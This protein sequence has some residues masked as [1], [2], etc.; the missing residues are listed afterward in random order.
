MC[1]KLEFLDGRINMKTLFLTKYDRKAATVRYRILQYVPYLES[2][3]IAC[4]ISPLFDDRYLVHLFKAGKRRIQDMA[5]AFVRRMTALF[6]LVFI[7]YDIVIIQAELFPYFPA[8][9]ERFLSLIGIK[10]VL[11]YDDAL[12]HQY[13]Q[14]RIGLVRW[15]LG[16]KIA[17]IMRG[18]EIV[19][20]GN[21][22][23][24]NYA[25]QAGARRIEIIPTVIDLDRYPISF[26][27]RP[28]NQVFTIGWIGSPSTSIYLKMIAPALAEA[29]ANGKGR[30]VLIGSGEVSLPGVPLEVL[31]WE[32]A[33]EVDLI[34]GFDVG[35]MPLP[36]NPWARGKCG[37]KLIQYMACGLPVIAS[38]VGVNS[39]I[40][41]DRVNGFL[42]ANHKG[43]V[44]ALNFLRENSEIRRAMG[45]EGRVAV[46]QKYCL[47]VTAPRLAQFLHEAV[48]QGKS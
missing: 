3:G 31:P 46:E 9:A 7:R 44:N 1:L 37:F 13:D 38:P 32:E 33:K 12:F 11:D 21:Q 5:K 35:I 34:N 4:T 43:W 23:I 26:R 24:A 20:A 36:D 27:K 25:H 10:Y 14:H 8:I 18:A 47:Q 45:T 19:I 22:Y 17:H 6:K 48:V 28:I 15:L 40:V 30:L 2:S 39:E 29:C 16:N 41:E 42:P